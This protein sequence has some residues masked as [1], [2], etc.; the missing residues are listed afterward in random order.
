MKNEKDR[1][2]KDIQVNFITEIKI[3]DAQRANPN[4][5]FSQFEMARKNLNM[6]YG[7]QIAAQIKS[8]NK[9]IIATD[10]TT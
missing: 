10:L 8:I 7:E 5:I 1:I 9:P 6:K 2:L 4:L 3:D